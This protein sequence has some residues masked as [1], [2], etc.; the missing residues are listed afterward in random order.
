MKAGCTLG[1]RACGRACKGTSFGRVSHRFDCCGVVDAHV[2][3]QPK[4][5]DDDGWHVVADAIRAG[6]LVGL[7]T[8]VAS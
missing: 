5:N 6:Y 2:P 8:T 3:H 7:S 4:R 1:C